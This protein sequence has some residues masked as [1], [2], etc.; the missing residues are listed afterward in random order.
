MAPKKYFK[1]EEEEEKLEKLEKAEREATIEY[2]RNFLNNSQKKKEKRE[3]FIERKPISGDFK[4]GDYVKIV[5]IQE[6]GADPK[7]VGSFGILYDMKNG[8]PEVVF[9]NIKGK[10]GDFADFASNYKLE[11]ADKCD[12]CGK[13]YLR[14]EIKNI[15]GRKMCG[16]CLEREK[17]A[18][19]KPA[20]RQSRADEIA[21]R[22][23]ARQ[24]LKE[25]LKSYDEPLNEELVS[26]LKEWAGKVY[27]F[28]E[29]SVEKYYNLGGPLLPGDRTL[30]HKKYNR[31]FVKLWDEVENFITT[32]IKN[33]SNFTVF[34]NL[35]KND[36]LKYLKNYSEINNHQFLTSK[37]SRD[38]RKSIVAEQNALKALKEII[39]RW[40]QHYIKYGE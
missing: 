17:A 11:H 38:I 27:N 20:K 2:D 3:Y 33:P 4:A 21:S 29:N 6:K 5:G 30:L 7:D 8:G 22:R 15:K 19:V 12:R 24:S 25:C 18:G 39:D 9:T 32:K 16:N 23:V 14:K 36:F 10:E 37:S 35:V 1:E 34:Q 28:L 13:L 31:K 26:K 40:K